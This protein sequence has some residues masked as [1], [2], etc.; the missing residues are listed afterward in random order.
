[1]ASSSSSSSSLVHITSPP[2]CLPA[3]DSED[4]DDD[5]ELNEEDRKAMEHPDYERLMNMIKEINLGRVPR[6][7]P[8]QIRM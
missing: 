8:S 6:I 4:S 3:A 5:L 1:M 7:R 2:P